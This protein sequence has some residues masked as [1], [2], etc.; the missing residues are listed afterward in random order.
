LINGHVNGRYLDDKL[1]WPIFECAENLNV[2]IYLHPN[3]PPQPVV[4]ACY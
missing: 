4:S 2:P 1:L 3:R